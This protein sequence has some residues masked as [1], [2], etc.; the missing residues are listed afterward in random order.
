LIPSAFFIFQTKNREEK[1]T[2]AKTHLFTPESVTSTISADP[3]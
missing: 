2:A 3:E 1:L